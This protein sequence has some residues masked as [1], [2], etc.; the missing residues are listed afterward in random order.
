[1]E[2]GAGK[3]EGAG[4]RTRSDCFLRGGDAVEGLIEIFSKSILSFSKKNSTALQNSC[5]MDNNSTERN[6][7]SRSRTLLDIPILPAGISLE[8]RICC[9]KKHGPRADFW[10]SV[11]VVFKIKFQML[12]LRVMMVWARGGERGWDWGRRFKRTRARDLLTGISSVCSMRAERGIEGGRRS[13]I[14][15]LTQTSGCHHCGFE[16]CG[17]KGWGVFIGRGCLVFGRKNC[18]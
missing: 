7:L 9:Q 4:R 6:H 18:K 3:G 13:R 15:L 16:C 17:K 11:R 12:S 14:H 5:S 1:M 10:V 8:Y 2:K